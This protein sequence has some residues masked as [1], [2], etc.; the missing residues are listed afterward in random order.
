MRTIVLIT[1]LISA[2]WT[3]GKCPDVRLQEDFSAPNY[4]GIWY[5]QLRS[6]TIP[7]QKAD[8]TVASYTLKGDG[9]VAVF[10]SDYCAKTDKHNTAV[11]TAWFKGPWGKVKF[12]PWL[13]AGDYRVVATDYK[14]YAIIFSCWHAWFLKTEYY[15]IL[16]REK[17]PGVELVKKALSLLQER[18]PGVNPED[19]RTTTQGGNCKYLKEPHAVR[20]E[21][22]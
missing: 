12:S 11:G 8:C 18:S 1:A 20:G 21:V 7:F 17:Q 9:S 13:P 4:M 16:T 22:Y 6:K 14:S 3:A 10:N 19:L 2:V 5:E 15:W